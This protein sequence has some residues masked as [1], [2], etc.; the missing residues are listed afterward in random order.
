MGNGVTIQFGGL[1]YSNKKIIKRARNNLYTGEFPRDLYHFDTIKY[2][3]KI[4]EEVPAI[5]KGDYDSHINGIREGSLCYFKNRYSG[6]KNIKLFDIGMEDFFLIHFLVSNKFKVYNQDRYVI[7]QSIKMMLLDSIYNKGQIQNIFKIYTESFVSY[8]NT[9][10]NIFTTNYD[11]NLEMASNSNVHYLHGAFYILA[12]VYD[13]NSFRNRLADN[14]F[15]KNK[16]SNPK[17]YEYLHSTALM[18]YS[19]EDKKFLTEY[20]DTANQGI[21]KFVEGYKT[22]ETIRSDVD[23]W[24]YAENDLVRNLHSAI[25][26]KLGEDV[27]FQTND[28]F[29]EF[30]E[31]EGELQILGLSPEND[32]HIFSRINEN[33]KITKMI[34]YYF[35]EDD[36][37]AALRVFDSKT[38]FLEP[39]KRFWEIHF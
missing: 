27:K 34:Y 17:G 5:L 8:L 25:M 19:E 6:W 11:Q 13:P 4:F 1:D 10:Q 20:P 37:E 16:L 22:N 3:E 15:V 24:E 29:N 28:S 9:F 7:T 35:N 26:L 39:V 38:L 21:E 31:I 14:Q 32:N 18:A 30:K 23:Q 33:S 2:F 12:D 36:K